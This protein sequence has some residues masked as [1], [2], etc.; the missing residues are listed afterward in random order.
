MID[1]ETI[2]IL[3]EQAKKNKAQRERLFKKHDNH[4]DLRA[5]EGWE[6]TI[7]WLENYL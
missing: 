5:S 1:K 7:T 2:A 4:E 6:Q 3:I